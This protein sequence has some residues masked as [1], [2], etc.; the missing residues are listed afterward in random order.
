M[1]S[2]DCDNGASCA[3]DCSLL[4]KW[5][6]SK[7]SR[8]TNSFEN[9]SSGNHVL[10]GVEV[11]VVLASLHWLATG[12]RDRLSE[13]SDVGC[14]SATDSLECGDLLCVET[15]SC[16]VRVWELG[17]ALSIEGGLE[18]LESKSAAIY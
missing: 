9:A 12:S 8:D 18:V 15:K 14:L 5:G 16:E 7:I 4:D 17:K 1:T 11:E 13:L 6:S 3:E 2:F 10:G